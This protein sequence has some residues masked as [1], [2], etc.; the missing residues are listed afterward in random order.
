MSHASM[1]HASMSYRYIDVNTLE[2]KGPL[3]LGLL[4]DPYQ[5]MCA[6]WD[7]TLIIYNLL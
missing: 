3:Y 4:A 7:K 1:S 6:L 2:H 5:T